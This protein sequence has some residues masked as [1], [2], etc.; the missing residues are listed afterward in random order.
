[1][2]VA[3]LKKL[4]G[5]SESVPAE[6]MEKGAEQQPNK[7]ASTASSSTTNSYIYDEYYA[8]LNRAFCLELFGPEH[9]Y[10]NSSDIQRSSARQIL[11][12][13]AQS[14]IESSQLPRKP[15]TLPSLMKLLKQDELSYSQIAESLLKDPSLTSQVLRTA[16]SPFFRLS[17]NTVEPLDQA[18][19]IMGVG[20]IKK[21]VSAAILLPVFKG[22]EKGNAFTESVWEW[23]LSSGKAVDVLFQSRGESEGSAYLL[24]LLPALA[25]LLIC[26]EIGVI[27]ENRPAEHKLIPSQKLDIFKQVG[28][29]YCIAIRKE[30]GLPDH[31]D[32]YLYGLK[33]AEGKRY[34]DALRAA[35]LVAQYALILAKGGAV[36]SL[37]QLSEITGSSLQENTHIMAQLKGRLAPT[38]D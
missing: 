17:E 20:G 7:V 10:Q 25:L 35:L 15:S 34:S 18:I 21:V 11:K 36:I 37:E 1:M 28:W 27:E 9:L 5:G 16:N 29:K 38:N 31:F 13:L 33:E 3:W 26:Q 32:D 24:G 30:W 22:E 8:E 6:P 19:L 4:F 23:A 12:K 2:A 14:N